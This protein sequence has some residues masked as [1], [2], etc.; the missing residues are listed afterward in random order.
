M[1]L[2]NKTYHGS[3]GSVGTVSNH[4]R[5]TS[6][7]TSSRQLPGSKEQS[8]PGLE[9]Q[10]SKS[11]GAE[12]LIH[13]TPEEP[14]RAKQLDRT[15]GRTR[16]AEGLIQTTF[17]DS[18]RA[19]QRSRN[20]RQ[21]TKSKSIP[22]SAS[23]AKAKE[24]T[25]QL[26]TKAKPGLEKRKSKSMIESSSSVR[27][28]TKTVKG[29]DGMQQTVI[30]SKPASLQRERSSTTVISLN[31]K[32]QETEKEKGTKEMRTKTKT[33]QKTTKA[34]TMPPP[35]KKKALDCSCI[36]NFPDDVW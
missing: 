13:S 32:S 21:K 26:A 22:Q 19:K 20:D 6:I 1:G 3:Q 35:I 30:K 34:P 15:L 36:M 9:R 31:P 29:K 12:G 33:W 27:E 17:E 16:S 2:G 5:S 14:K 8:L 24:G 11:R 10:S 28:N 18:Q 25:S 4:A 23:V 7:R